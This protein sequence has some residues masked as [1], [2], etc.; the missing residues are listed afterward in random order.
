MAAKARVEP[1]GSKASVALCAFQVGP[2]PQ[3]VGHCLPLSQVYWQDGGSE[4]EQ[5]GLEPLPIW[6]VGIAGDGLNS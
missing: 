4:V 5:Q 6:A 2:G 3:H 1:G